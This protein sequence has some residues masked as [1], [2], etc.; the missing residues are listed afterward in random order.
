MMAHEKRKESIVSRSN[1]HEEALLMQAAVIRVYT[2]SLNQHPCFRI[3]M[4]TCDPESISLPISF[5]QSFFFFLIG[6][7]LI[8]S[9]VPVSAV[10]QNDSY[11]HIYIPFYILVHYTLSQ[12]IE[13][14]SLCSASTVGPCCLSI[15][16]M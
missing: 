9:F 2:L 11:V 5:Y 15:L 13:Y 10:Q 8:Y 12:G 14:S 3:I 6:V 7:W 16:D 4:S 1:C